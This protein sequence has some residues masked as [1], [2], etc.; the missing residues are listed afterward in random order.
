MNQNSTTL[1]II[2]TIVSLLFIINISAQNKF[3]IELKDKTNE[4]IENFINDPS[5]MLS[6]RSI[7][8]RQLLNISLDSKDVPIDNLLI[9]QCSET[10]A[11]ILSSS[12]WLNT[13]FISA[14]EVQLNQIKNLSFV[15]NI[16][17]LETMNSSKKINISPYSFS[18]NINSVYGQSEVFVSQIN[19]DYVHNKGYKGEGVQIAILDAGFQGVNTADAF[20]EIR[21]RNGIIGKYNFVENSTDVYKS[22]QHGTMVLSTI[23]IDKPNTY[24]GTAYKADFWLFLTE[25]VNSETPIEEFNWIAAAE[26]ADSVGV[27]V[28]NSSLGYYDYD[29]PYK[30]YIYNDMDGQTT[31]VSRGARIGSDKGMLMVV[32]AGNEGNNSWKYIGTPADAIDVIAVGA[33]N[34]SGTAAGFT[35]YGPTS[36]GRVKPD[37]SAMGV[38]VPVYNRDGNLQN[39]NGTSF[40]SP[41]T[42][43][44]VACLRQ[45]FPSV[46]VK[47]I[48]DALQST[49]SIANNTDNRLGY[50]IAN[51]ESAYIKLKDLLGLKDITIKKLKITPNPVSEKLIIDGIDNTMYNYFISD[52]SGK[53]IISGKANFQNGINLSNLTKGYYLLVVFDK[54]KNINLPFI[55]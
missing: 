33:V 12:K 13:L 21:D 8:R 55:K 19:I 45:A 2:F 25:D 40:S 28:I 9:K 31:F 23:G 11:T 24:L 39:V 1:K 29:R 17:E 47:N 30:S 36:D 54:N 38:S 3:A 18:K 42:A 7:N 16:I 32:S 50:G 10:G 37:V 51:F 53:M 46:S 35:S 48:I 43:G 22:D 27:D 20:K 26:Y 15:S 4:R 41:I 44:S 34:S 52:S 14:T 6:Q 5:K 49:A